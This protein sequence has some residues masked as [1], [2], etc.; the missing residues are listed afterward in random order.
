MQIVRTLICL[1]ALLPLLHGA[2]ELLLFP[3]R[4]EVVTLVNTDDVPLEAVIHDVWPQRQSV[5]IFVPEQ[6]N[7]FTLPLATFDADSQTTLQDW[8]FKRLANQNLT[9]KV[10]ERLLRRAGNTPNR[11]GLPQAPAN[12]INIRVNEQIREKDLSVEIRNTSA[13]R[14]QDLSVIFALRIAREISSSVSTNKTRMERTVR[15]RIK[16]IGI[17]SGSTAT[18]DSAPVALLSRTLRYDIMNTVANP[19]GMLTDQ[20]IRYRFQVSDR[21]AA[22]YILIYYKEE[23]VAA[24]F[25]H[26]YMVRELI[27]RIQQDKDTSQRQD[28]NI[29]VLDEPF[30]YNRGAGR[31]AFEDIFFPR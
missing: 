10:E 14:Q 9:L 23:L 26:Q 2:D 22:Y 31:N 18:L 28:D 17:D 13:Y 16:D 8:Y 25:S 6:G 24:T 11:E 1:F 7:S 29:E 4:D 30:N 19:G 12:A 20:L 21:I 15:T 3:S 5:R 27:E